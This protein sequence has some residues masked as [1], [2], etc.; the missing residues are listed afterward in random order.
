[1]EFIKSL[2]LGWLTDEK[3]RKLSFGEVKN[4]KT[5]NTNTFEPEMGGLFCPRI[6]GP[7]RNYQCACK[8]DQ[9]RLVKNQVC[10]HCGVLIAHSNVRR[11]RMGHYKL[12]SPVTNT[13]LFK[14][15][16]PYLEQILEIPGRQ[17]KDLIYY[18]IYI[19]LDKGNSKILQNKQILTH[20]IDPELVNEV[21]EEIIQAGEGSNKASIIKRAHELQ[22]NL[23]GQKQSDIQI[24]LDKVQKALQETSDEEEKVKLEEKRSK[25]Q[26]LLE[27]SQLQVI[28]LEDY[29]DFF[30]KHWKV[31]VETGSLALAEL[32][33]AVNLEEELKKAYSIPQD[34]QKQAHNKLK[35]LKA[36]VK[37]KIPLQGLVLN[38]LPIIP[39]GLRPTTKL[40]E[41]TV[42]VTQINNFYRKVIITNERLENIIEINKNLQ[43][44]VLFFDIVH[45]EQKRLQLAVDQLMMGSS[46][47]GGDSKKQPPVTKSLLQM[48]SG[49]EGIIRK[50]SLGKRVD[51]SARSVITPNP[52]LN[53]NQV[54]LP[55]EMA[56]ILYKP[57]LLNALLKQG[58]TLDQAKQLFLENH[59]IIFVLLNKIIQNHPVFLNRAP[60]L[61]RL[62]IQAFNPVLFLEKSIQL[63]P[64]VTIAFNADFDGDQMAVHLP[65]TKKSRE[66]IQNKVMASFHI[67]DPKNGNLI[68]V[69]SQDTILGIYYLTRL[70]YSSTNKRIPVYYETSQMSKDYEENRLDIAAPIFLPFPL[71][72]PNSSFEIKDNEQR[73][74]LT[75]FGR[76]KFNQILPPSFPHYLNSLRFF[77]RQH[78]SPSPD[79]T[80]AALTDQKE[81]L[82]SSGWQKKDII[83]FLNHLVKTVSNAEMIVF[84]DKLKNLGFYWATKSGISVSLFDLPE[85]AEKADIVQR[86]QEKLKQIDDYY[87]QGFYNEQEYVQQKN[88]TWAE[89]KEELEAEVIRKLE[90]KKN[91]SLYLLWDSGARSNNENLNQIFGMR[92]N[93]ND[94]QGNTIETPILSSLKDGLTSF[95][96]FIS[97]YGAMK[98]MIDIALK[99]SEAGYLTRRLVETVQNLIITKEDCQTDEGIWLKEPQ[100]DGAIDSPL[101]NLV[102]RIRGRYSAQDITVEGKKLLSTNTLI[103]DEKIAVL[104][105]NNILAV[106]VRSPFTCSLIQ[107]ICQKCYGCDL[108]KN[109]QVIELGSAVGIIAAQSLGEPGTQLT[110]RTFHDTGKAE[111]D[112]T[113]GLPKAKEILDNVVPVKLRQAVVAREDGKIVEIINKEDKN[114]TIIKQV[115][116]LG[117]EV[118]YIIE[119][120]KR[121]KVTLGQTVRKGTSL[122]AGKI[123]LEHL[124]ETV[125]RE[126]C[127]SHIKEE[128]LK[129]YY[130]QGIKVNEKHVELFARQMLGFV[131]V[132]QPGDSDHLIGDIVSYQEISNL[133]QQLRNK[134]QTPVKFKNLVFGLKQVARHLPSF[135]AGVSFQD[136][137]KTLI[138]YSIFQPVDHLWGIKENLVVGQLAPIG[139]GLQEKNERLAKSKPMPTKVTY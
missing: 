137:S 115:D 13:L 48:L 23:M 56:L 131:E 36:F 17:L 91:S 14:N 26:K 52:E 34:K 53:L 132:L 136:T 134:N 111:E 123:N 126:S 12:A 27:E 102:E 101:S 120:E 10:E 67:L 35:T 37:N 33:K 105:A 94:Y 135:L 72:R 25:L 55:V 96:F 11:W 66:E 125:G 81:V 89:C 50:Y 117:N 121:I 60:T 32:L 100:E 1:M 31:R 29:L 133:N 49:K 130:D 128:I 106:K 127:Q 54:G 20:K 28:F 6:F 38:Y 79:D 3:I 22:T 2:E 92:G 41:G 63:H 78:F 18:K 62:G 58:R 114:Q 75:T 24:K 113:Q 97:V 19:V 71:C 107:G 110:M 51:Y 59:P 64:L 46:E 70:G 103:L 122:T 45:N 57:F 87:E 98:G 69:P 104:K 65:L 4:S 8:G 76:W 73:F 43:T 82:A 83:T 68:S 99:T 5:L 93:M 129:V 44:R 77:N 15:I 85:I 109:K 21:L 88:N 119:S 86:K 74:L 16:L 40:D 138:H 112:I 9:R 90:T 124:L 139:V 108:G 95:E 116:D 61:H 118:S 42:A 47:E 39:A 84:L 80:F 7:W 30:S